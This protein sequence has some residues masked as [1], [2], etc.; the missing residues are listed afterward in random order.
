MPYKNP[1]KQKQYHK[2]YYKKNREE[3]LK[4]SKQYNEENR[5]E[6]SKRMKK[7]YQKNK[8]KIKKRT[9][10]YYYKNR[11]KCIRDSVKWGKENKDKKH[12]NQKKYYEKKKKESPE[13]FNK[14]AIREYHE[15]IDNSRKKQREYRK[16]N[17]FKVRFWKHNRRA[18]CNGSVV[19]KQ[20]LT[21]EFE[22]GV[23]KILE[24]QDYK[25]IYCG[26]DITESF[27]LDH[28]KP[29]SR[30]GENVVENIDLTC[31]DCN[32]RKSTRTKKEYLRVLGGMK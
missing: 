20:H 14:K 13:Y 9:R 8:D 21:K 6:R 4:K 32:T 23:Q 26:V 31:R 1:K 29:L 30:G 24:E 12:K 16:K 27:S 10:K 25:C 15:D 5:G 19:D 2:E 3:L 17:P 7:Y 18:R 28:R 11:K 22:K